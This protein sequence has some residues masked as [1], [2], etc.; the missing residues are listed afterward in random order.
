[1]TP[2]PSPAPA[3]TR[4][5]LPLV[6]LLIATVTALTGRQLS[7]IAIPWLVLTTTG[8]AGRA[9]LVA[10][11]V[12]LPGLVVGL[13]GGVLID[14]LGYRRV[15]IAANLV[16]AGGIVMIPIL[17]VTVGLAFWQLLLFVFIGS[18][19]EIPAI[20]AGRSMVPELAELARQPLERV[21]A[22]F[23][24]AGNLS[25]LVGTPVAG[26]LVAGIGARNVLWIDA[27]MSLT[28]AVVL[29]LW[30]PGRL[31]A[32]RAVMVSRG[33]ANDL[34]AGL[35]FI[36]NDRLLW[37]MAVVLAL[38]NAIGGAAYNVLL[39]VYAEGTLDSSI[40][41]G[42]TFTA[43]GLG[44]LA[45]STL[46]G[47][48]AG[49]LP[50]RLV[51]SVA[52]LVVPVD[53][54]VFLVSPGVGLLIAA[55][56]LSGL[57]GGPLNPLMVT[58]RHER[59]PAELRGRVFSTYSAIAGSVQPVGFLAAGWAVDALGFLPAVLIFAVL[60]QLVGVA[61]VVVPGFRDLDRPA[62]PVPA[63]GVAASGSVP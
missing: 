61:T 8:S 26:L 20:T 59:S 16:S 32:R 25:L 42:L 7:G 40:A 46:Y 39:P 15:A 33:F 38:S 36:R 19:L 55:F 6:A 60:T 2:S 29:A 30:V 23:E 57:V 14:R 51:W 45:G 35:R 27:A 63:T 11:V 54:W 1:M 44:A 3:V 62:E 37:P 28:G 21:N 31:F 56:M 41:L 12:V 4:N 58:I 5:R 43:L 52:F 47:A 13:L 22:L 50:R 24:S 34:L 18:L 17:Y 49:R 53:L 48:L 10:A 9:G